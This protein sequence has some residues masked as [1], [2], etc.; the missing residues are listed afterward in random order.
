MW[1]ENGYEERT[2]C[3]IN[4]DPNFDPLHSDPRF[5]DLLQPQT[6]MGTGSKVPHQSRRR[7]Q[8]L[9]PP[10]SVHGHLPI[11]HVCHV[12]PS[13]EKLHDLHAS[14][15]HLCP[16]GFRIGVL[17]QPTNVVLVEHEVHFPQM[18]LGRLSRPVLT[19]FLALRA[20]F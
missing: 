5:Q 19:E 12:A 9:I 8:R 1:L 13:T 4:V 16:T 20:S 18:A 2:R 15:C 11:Q 14:P 7:G 6:S 10:L 17:F 3:P